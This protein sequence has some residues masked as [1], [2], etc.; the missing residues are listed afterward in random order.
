MEKVIITIIL[1]NIDYFWVWKHDEFI[2]Y[3]SPKKT[4]FPLI[5]KC[6]HL[7]P[8]YKHTS[9]QTEREREGWGMAMRTSII[10]PRTPTLNGLHTTTSG[11]WRADRRG[12]IRVRCE[13]PGGWALENGAAQL[14]SAR[15]KPG[16]IWFTE[17][18]IITNLLYN[19]KCQINHFNSIILVWRS[20]DPKLEITIKIRLIAQ[21]YYTMSIKAFKFVWE[22]YSTKN[23]LCAKK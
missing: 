17:L 6:P 18:G 22:K 21:P 4:D 20:F 3:F 13:Q 10:Y 19:E 16:V 12:E 11:E 23:I 14:F 9:R 2:Q 5:I 7:P 15:C 1:D 8:H